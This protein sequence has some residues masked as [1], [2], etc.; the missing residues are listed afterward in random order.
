[1]LIAFLNI[2]VSTSVA[3]AADTPKLITNKGQFKNDGLGEVVQKPLEH[4]IYD[5]SFVAYDAAFAKEFALV[6]ENVT[7]LD[8]GLRFM[9]IRM[10]TEGQQTNCYYNVI[11]DKTVDIDFPEENFYLDN[12]TP[13]MFFPW[14]YKSSHETKL[15]IRD[16]T[17]RKTFEENQRF[18]SRTYIAN[19]GYTFNKSGEPFSNGTAFD[20][21][22]GYYIQDRP[23][24]FHVISTYRLCG[25]G[26]V[27]QF[28]D[29]ALWIR[30]KGH[31]TKAI[32]PQLENYYLFTIPSKIVERFSPVLLEFAKIKREIIKKSL[33]QH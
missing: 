13:E 14:N 24:P 19:R 3:M 20:V 30:K 29:P 25:G 15:H 11:L 17:A 6:E 27:Y 21:S 26:K 2:I 8:E 1:M 7:A 10:V 5:L 23:V 22:V 32:L 28:P 16:L 31:E 9:E 18:N 33:N 4:N 12:K